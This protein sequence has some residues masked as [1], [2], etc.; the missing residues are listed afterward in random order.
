MLIVCELTLAGI[1]I[2]QGEIIVTMNTGQ[3]AAPGHLNR[4]ADR[5]P[6]SRS[7]LMKP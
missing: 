5:N 7:L 2:A 3:V 1:F 6:L 4:A